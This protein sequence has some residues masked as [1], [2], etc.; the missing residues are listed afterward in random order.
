M[1]S[2]T[3]K[4]FAELI[5]IWML[6]TVG[7]GSAAVTLMLAEGE[8]KASAFNIGIGALGGLGDWLAIGLCF[9][10]VIATAI[11]LFGPV[12]GCHINPSVT[13]AL[14]ITKRIP[15]KDAIV[16][17][18]AQF[19]G[20]TLGSVTL[21]GLLGSKGATVGG[22]GAPGVFPG[23]SLGQVFLAELVGTFLLMSGIMAYAV[24]KRAP[25]SLVGLG[26]GLNIALIITAFGNIS[27]QGI[28]PARSF[29]PIL[30]DSLVGGPNGWSV[31]WIFLVAPIIGAVLAVW[32]YD[33]VVKEAET[34]TVIASQ[35]LV[36]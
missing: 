5:G 36:S 18:I 31:Y 27:G 4:F 21:L 1:S 30:V 34:N 25:K 14:W 35:D 22:L 26:I 23:M 16:Y 2:L 19:I 33:A 17:I 10:I 32:V 11:Y 3:K 12:S 24:D 29:G 9:G 13:I 7:T 20:A 15:T 6:V 8:K 28:N